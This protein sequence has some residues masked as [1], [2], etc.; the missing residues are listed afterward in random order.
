MPTKIKDVPVPVANIVYVD[1]EKVLDNPYQPRHFYQPKKVDELA[2]SIEQIGILHIPVGRRQGD[3]IQLAYGHVRKRAFIKLKARIPKKFP[4]MPVEIKDLDDRQ[5]AVFALEENMKRSDITPIDMARSVTRYLEVFEDA[6]ET[7][8]AEKLSMTQGHI[9]NMRR[10]MRLPEGILD[11][12]D[13]G[14]ISFTMARELCIF[15]GLRA[16]GDETRWSRGDNKQVKIP[17]DATWLMLDTIKGISS[18]EASGASGQIRHPCTV[19]GIQKAIHDVVKDHFKPLGVGS[20]YGYRYGG[21]DGLLFDPKQAGCEKCDKTIKTHPTKSGSCTWCTGEKCWDKHQQAHKEE[22]ARKTK[23]AME[24][25]VLARV[26][27]AEKE[28][29]TISQ[30][31]PR[32]QYSPGKW[33][34]IVVGASMIKQVEKSNSVEPLMKGVV[35]N[36]FLYQG[37]WHICAGADHLP[38]GSYYDCY[39]MLPRPQYSGPTHT[40]TFPEGEDRDKFYAGRRADTSGFYHGLLVMHGK[41]E[42]VLVGP[43]VVFT[44]TQQKEEPAAELT[45]QPEDEI[46]D[47]IVPEEREAARERIAQ[48]KQFPE[49]LI[50]IT[51]LNVGKCDGSAFH[52]TE[53]GFACSDHMG[54]EDAPKVRARAAI[55]VPP[56]LQELAKEKAGSRAEVFDLNELRSGMYGA[57]KEGYIDLGDVGV[58]GNMDLTECEKTCTQGFH[59]AFDSRSHRYM[60]PKDKGETHFVC[61]NPKCVGQKKAAYTRAKNARGMEKKKAEFAAIRKV[62]D[63]TVTLDKPRLKV[64]LYGLLYSQ[65]HY[66]NPDEAVNWFVDHLKV[67]RDTI[68]ANYGNG[69]DRDKA[70]VAIFAAAEKLEELAL[71]KLMVEY[72][73]VMM[74]YKGDVKGY[75]AQATEALNWCGAG[76]QLPRKKAAADPA[77]SEEEN[78]E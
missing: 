13:E 25:D 65:H 27:A 40:A 15:D 26:A 55:P 64:L 3:D 10:V 36:P 1:P 75:K 32:G 73:L 67:P 47:Y 2:S 62:V 9:A 21:S 57:L 76:I 31:I 63:E 71:A 12:V 66:G 28:R 14:R 18:P 49:R 5:M 69:I 44:T 56:E 50:C 74:T 30:E 42:R 61:S 39:M 24:A 58:R 6:T 60:D 17:K 19:D 77:G 38:D 51:C 59:Y 72:S 53:D 46:V 7:S 33:Q 45:A 4:T 23:K 68:K 70:V 34:I 52:T 20:E 16:P 35:V 54:K 43:P 11:K 37:T 48:L 8:L 22:M 41:E 29:Q 78:D